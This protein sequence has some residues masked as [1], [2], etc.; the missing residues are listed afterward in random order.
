MN[1]L[2]VYAVNV[3][4]GELSHTHLTRTKAESTGD[5]PPLA[6][7]LGVAVDT[8]AVELFPVAD[9]TPLKLTDYLR[10]GFDVAEKSLAPHTARLTA[11]DGHV[12]LVPDDALSAAPVAS[13]Q[14][15]AIAS[16]P[17]LQADQDQSAVPKMP[18]PA[19]Q[20]PDLGTNGKKP[21]SDAR[22][23]GMVAMAALVVL[24]GLVI[25]MVLIA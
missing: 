13:A 16:L 11:L 17:T 10:D 20:V 2:H 9:L 7:W 12:L 22:I 21:M 6:D 4:L 5:L 18:E 3:D 19:Q 8:E 15:T 24:F 14:L 23:S 25:V 1:L